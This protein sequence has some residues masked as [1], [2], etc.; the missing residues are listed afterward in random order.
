VS[1]RRQEGGEQTEKTVKADAGSGPLPRRVA[2]HVMGGGHEAAPA[3]GIREKY[4]DVAREVNL[5]NK[6]LSL[7]LFYF[8]HASMTL[9]LLLSSPCIFASAMTNFGCFLW[10]SFKESKN[11]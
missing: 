9:L 1:E 4:R 10:P 8:V 11:E 2:L 6:R 5:L 3:K 7:S